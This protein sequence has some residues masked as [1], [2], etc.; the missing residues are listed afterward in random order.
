M[1]MKRSHFNRRDFLTG[2]LGIVT[3]AVLGAFSIRHGAAESMLSTP[4]PD[5][6]VKWVV[7]YTAG[8]ATDVI[9]RLICQRLSERLRQSFFVVNMPGAGSTV[10]TQEVI[11]SSPDGY[12]LLLIST[13]N[14]INASFDKSLP[15]DFSKEIVPV[16]GLARIP[17]V[18][19]INNDIPA[20]TI[21]EFI[22]YAK[23]NPI[24]LSVG[25]SGV[26]TS[27]HLSGELFKAMTGIDLTHVPYKG[28][29]P[30]LTDLM[31]GQIQVMFDNVTSSAPF[32]REGKV[33]AL[34]VTTRERS[35]S[36]PDVP[37][38]SDS[39]P[40]YETNSFYGVGAPS[41]TASEIVNLL[42]TEIN[43]A[44]E[45]PQIK[46]QFEDLGAIPITGNASQFAAMLAAETDRWRKIVEASGAKKD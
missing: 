3:T 10:G 6:Q 4:Y 41:G 43:L 14:A 28:S 29:A 23:S 12:T 1:A 34:G 18:M 44:L 46:K 27:L 21:L 25:S 16:S 9:S 13:A 19:V 36:L 24:H 20:H 26:G 45:D 38:I 40:G 17:L 39:L 31:S 5:H 22:A 32:V 37:P 42:N 7:P 30:A 11:N 33:R 35:I 2:A 15:F 8:G